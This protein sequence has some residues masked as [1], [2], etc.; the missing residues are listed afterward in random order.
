MTDVIIC[1]FGVAGRK[2]AESLQRHK[3]DYTTIDIL[4]QKESLE[5]HIIG[6]ATSEEILQKAEIEEAKTI[7]AITDDDVT[8]AFIALIARQLNKSITILAR[9]EEVENIEKMDKAGADYI[10]SMAKVGRFIAKSAIE[11]YIAD[12][13]DMVNLKEDLEMM[14]I[15]LSEKSKLVDK[16]LARSKI[17]KKTG[18][19]IIAIRRGDATIYATAEDEILRVDDKIIVIGTGEQIRSFYNIAGPETPI[20]PMSS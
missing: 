7:V 4:I 10:F 6:D 15:D 1:G 8:N 5:N 11:P 3:I 20:E 17:W 13:L 18:A 12:F 19:H 16:T 9:V 14:Q 2:V